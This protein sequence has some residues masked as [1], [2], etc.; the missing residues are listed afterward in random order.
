MPAYDSATGLGSTGRPWKLESAGTDRSGAFRTVRCAPGFIE[1]YAA[2]RCCGRRRVVVFRSMRRD[3][4]RTPAQPGLDKT[5]FSGAGR[6]IWCCVA[7][8]VVAAISGVRLTGSDSSVQLRCGHPE[9]QRARPK[10]ANACVD[11]SCARTTKGLRSFAHASLRSQV[12]QRS[13]S[14][15]LRAAL[16]VRRSASV[17]CGACACVVALHSQTRCAEQSRQRS[18]TECCGRGSSE[19]AWEPLWQQGQG[20]RCTERKEAG[21]SNTSTQWRAKTLLVLG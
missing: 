20:S 7:A 19:H 9:P 12:E 17:S 14:S 1:R 2:L 3:S 13:S 8:Q 4:G 11:A 5:P 18:S 16:P 21:I 15:M 6:W 10:T